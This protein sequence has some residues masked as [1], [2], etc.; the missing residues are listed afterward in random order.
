MTNPIESKPGDSTRIEAIAQQIAGYR[1]DGKKIS[2]DAPKWNISSEAMALAIQDRVAELVGEPVAG[3]KFGAADAEGQKRLGLSQPFIGRV[4]RSR[5]QA[6]PA[7]LSPKVNPESYIESEIAFSFG[8]DLPPRATPYTHAEIKA[9]LAGCHPSYEIV[10]FS[11]PSRDG[12]VG[13]DFV[14]DNGGCGGMVTGPSPA[15]WRDLDLLRESIVYDVDGKT[16]AQGTVKKTNDQLI[17]HVV[18]FVNYMGSRGTTL[19][20]GQF[21]TTGTWTGMPPLRA[22][23]TGTARY[24][25][26]GSINATMSGK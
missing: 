21:I 7:T 24:S 9:S 23:Q 6:S 3:W 25:S 8:A 13:V 10:D 12:L 4:F 14:A 26:L 11:W 19:K 1:R 20:A 17:E 22:G 15:N 18:W 5:Q 16:E 2:A